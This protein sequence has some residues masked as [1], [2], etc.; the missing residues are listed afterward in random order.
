MRVPPIKLRTSFL[1]YK[2]L[3]RTQPRE[4][5]LTDRPPPRS[6]G[7][8]GQRED[9]QGRKFEMETMTVKRSD[10]KPDFATEARAVA[11]GSVKVTPA[12]TEVTLGPDAGKGHF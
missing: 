11:A 5:E 4:G 9:P 3:C 6:G 2:D 8:V 10:G 7:A 12:G 1:F